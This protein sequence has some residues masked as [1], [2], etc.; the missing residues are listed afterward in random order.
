MTPPPTRGQAS[1]VARVTDDWY[2]VC[3]SEEL[4]KKPIQS[5]LLGT[6]LAVFRT[7]GGVGALL[8]RCPHRNVPLSLGAV[9]GDRLEC[10]YHGWEFDLQGRCRHIPC[11]VGDP[12]AKAR[13]V[14]SYAAREQDGFVWV[15]G[16]AGKEPERDPYRF[17][18]QD[19]P[20]Y[21]HAGADIVLEGTVHAAAENALDV[22]HTAY[23]H[24]GLFR[25]PG[26]GKEI[27]VTIRRW[28]EGCEAE[29]AG[30]SVPPGVVG[31]VLAP[32]GGMVTHFD[33]FLLP[34]ITQV[35]YALG[36]DSH[37]MISSSLTPISD[38]VTKLYGQV[39][40][41]TPLKMPMKVLAQVLKP[42]A[43]VILGQDAKML[44]HQT[45]ATKRFGGEQLVST[46]VDVLGPH[47]LRL[48]KDAEKGKRGESDEVYEKKMVMRV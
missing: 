25:K 37:I 8:D 43:M 13:E 44:K 12:D 3:R 48:L 21:V 4:G 46:D 42:L 7:S 22:P 47:I 41:R 32:G 34:S 5:T 9:K 36:D 27:D 1:S 30:E 29:Y 11:L 39:A 2:V 24:G 31:K 28:G 18:F 45:E 14:E 6:P 20:R 15:Y 26:I 40:I 16:A 35:E 19:D 33:R 23:L 38:F 10:G 17:P